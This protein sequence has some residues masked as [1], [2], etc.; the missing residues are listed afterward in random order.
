MGKL[1]KVDVE[2]VM[3]ALHLTGMA[4]FAERQ[5]SSL[6]DGEFQ[7]VMIA[8]M[9][10]Q[11]AP[12]LLLD[13]PTTHLDLPSGIELL[14]LL[15]KLAQEHAKTIVFTTHDL[16]LVLRMDPYM[17]LLGGD[18]TWVQGTAQEVANHTLMCKFLRTDQVRIANGQLEFTPAETWKK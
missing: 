2:A 8:K 14:H 12:L 9:L 11:D 13:E 17:V 16:H 3:H 4:P 18:G 5:V 1:A 10:A 6:S 7:K 15:R